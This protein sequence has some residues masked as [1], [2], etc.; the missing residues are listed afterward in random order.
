MQGL[1]RDSGSADI[2]TYL[3]EWHKS[4]FLG[5]QPGNVLPEKAG[6]AYG[7]PPPQHTHTHTHTHTQRFVRGPALPT[8][9]WWS[10]VWQLNNMNI[11]QV[12][13]NNMNC[14]F[15]YSTH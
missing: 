7:P 10:E 12:A 6:E 14:L 3:G 15:C 1:R 2:L 4:E 5:Y 8:K 9:K 11:S 13:T